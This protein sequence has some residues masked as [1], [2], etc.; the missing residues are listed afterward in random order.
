MV[1]ARCSEATDWSTDGKRIL[2]NTADGRTWL[3]ELTTRRKTEL[4]ATSHWIATDAFSPDNRWFSFLDV[5][6]A[7]ERAYIAPVGDTPIPEREWIG[8]IDGEAEAWSPD[9]NLLYA[10]S[11][12][13]GHVCIWAQRLDPSTKRPVGAPFA[14]FH[15]HHTR[16]SLANQTEVT[17]SI[18]GK[19]LV[20]SLG[21]R[22]GNIWMAEWK[23][24]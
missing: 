22:T 15:S 21:E 11:E 12:R 16:L 23:Q 10:T 19:K 2:G 1:C 4:L 3:L 14:V 5:N 6:H 24:Y 17:L 8:I 13:D 18:G 20:F 7:L 9:G